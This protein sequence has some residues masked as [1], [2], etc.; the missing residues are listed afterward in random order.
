MEQQKTQSTNGTPTVATHLIP[1]DRISVNLVASQPGGARMSVAESFDHMGNVVDV[2]GS[3]VPGKPGLRIELLS[4]NAAPEFPLAKY[5]ELVESG[6]TEAAEDLKMQHE[7]DLQAF[8]DE[9][10]ETLPDSIASAVLDWAERAHGVT[11]TD[12]GDHPFIRPDQVVVKN[13]V[14][15]Q[16]DEP[17]VFIVQLTPSWG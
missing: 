11:Q 9:G 1:G 2:K 10:N 15:Q 7:L 4:G 6:Q 3:P 14:R 13:V 17:G 16:S 5:N 8:E 12:T